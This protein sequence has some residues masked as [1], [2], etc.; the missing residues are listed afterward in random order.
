MQKAKFAGRIFLIMQRH[1]IEGDGRSN[2][3][4]REQNAGNRC[5]KL[6]FYYH[7]T[8]WNCENVLVMDMAQ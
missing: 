3:M 2:K 6:W 4:C 7:A 1:L 8:Y 5:G